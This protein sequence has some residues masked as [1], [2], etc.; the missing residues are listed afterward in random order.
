MTTI[1]DDFARINNTI[2]SI[3][4]GV[5]SVKTLRRD[6]DAARE[7]LTGLVRSSDECDVLSGDNVPMSVVDARLIE[8]ART[9]LDAPI[10]GD[11]SR[12]ERAAVPVL[13][14]PK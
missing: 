6:H 5:E 11:A 1:N 12:F 3:K 13:Q 10:P 7:L 14:F 4:A 9:F 8:R 2:E